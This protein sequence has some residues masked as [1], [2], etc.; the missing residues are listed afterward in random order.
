MPRRNKVLNDADIPRTRTS[1]QPNFMNQLLL[2]CGC[3]LGALTSLS[4]GRLLGSQSNPSAS[5]RLFLV[6]LVAAFVGGFVTGSL[7]VVLLQSSG[8]GRT[9]TAGFAAIFAT[10]SALSRDTLSPA[11]S[12]RYVLAVMLALGMFVGCLAAVL[13]G[14]SLTFN[15]P[16]EIVNFSLTPA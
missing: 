7:G 1:D 10:I 4:V 3:I 13:A 6:T 5:P 16:G 9:L 15:T 11:T 8:A 12:G 2:L 14:K